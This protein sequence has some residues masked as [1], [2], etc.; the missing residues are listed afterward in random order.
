MKRPAPRTSLL[1]A[2]CLLVFAFAGSSL[3]AR[4]VPASEGIPNF[5]RVS[6][7]LFR[8]AQPDERGLENLQRFG[9]ATIINLRTADDAVPGEKATARRLGIGYVNVPL[10]GLSAPGTADVER[11]LALIASSPP[12]VFVHCEH[13]A[14]RTGTIVACYRMQHDGWSAAQAMAEAKLYGISFFQFGMKRFIRG[15][16]G[17]RK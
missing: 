1:A 8:G 2:V 6:S 3:F 15:F 16:A 10:P 12:P 7:A 14:D 9:V 5:G 4:G 17:Q 11:V 13:G